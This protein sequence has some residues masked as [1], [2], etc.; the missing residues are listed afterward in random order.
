MSYVHYSQ[1]CPTIMGSGAVEA[2][3]IKAK[4][5]K[6]KKVVIVIDPGL[7][8]T[9][10][11]DK[12]K[13]SL[14]DQGI[15]YVLYNKVNVDPLDTVCEEGAAFAMEHKVDGV[16][17]VGGGSSLDCSKAIDLL[18][19][20]PA[21]LSQY[22]ES[23]DYKECRP[24]F[25][26]PTTTGTGSENT[27]YGVISDTKLN[28]KKVIFKTG[29]YAICDPELTYGL[30]SALT[31]ATGMDAFAHAAET[32][33]GLIQNP[34]TD[35]LG[36][37]AIAK[38]VKWLPIAVK[39]PGN[40]EARE[41]MML[42]SN[43]AG[44]AFTEMG[45]HLGHAIAQC[46]GGAFHVTHG[47]SCAWAL[48]ATMAYAAETESDKVK[49]VADAM[50]ISYPEDVTPKQIGTIVADAISDLMRTLE[51][52]PMSEYGITREALIGI[53]DIVMKD[54]CWPVI[55]RPL[56]KGQLEEL[57]GYVYDSYQG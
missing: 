12:V 46:M 54:N 39:E 8:K 18:M 25:L 38:I 40:K 21:P 50:G 15:G 14:E 2:L 17:G 22:Y 56:D 5:Y 47:I 37:Y 9:D 52:K 45:C 41:E 51:L 13:K 32:M 36:K 24:L 20:N 28:V 4:E 42:A 55:P 44:I 30:P 27:I 1:T 3:G 23:W 10:V 33:T 35:A 43:M 53:A 31:A 19:S 7:S 11:L 48:P 57:L 6:V 16:V 26:V 49:M 29:T 34:K